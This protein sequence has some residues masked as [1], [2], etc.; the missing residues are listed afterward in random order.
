MMNG[1]QIIAWA[2]KQ[3]EER[4]IPPHDGN[5]LIFIRQWQPNYELSAAKEGQS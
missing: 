3:C 5:I 2:V 4:K 1:L